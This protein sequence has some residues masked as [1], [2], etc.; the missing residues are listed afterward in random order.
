MEDYSMGFVK[1]MASTAGRILRVVA[2]LVLIYVGYF[3]I[4]GVGG[5]ILAVVGLAP[6]AAG[7]F[8]FCLLAPLFGAP[9]SGKAIRKS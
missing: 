4:K 8:D 9:L 6:I 7:V 2:G 1:F 5:D 3:V